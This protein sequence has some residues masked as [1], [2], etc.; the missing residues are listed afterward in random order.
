MLLEAFSGDIAKICIYT[1]PKLYE[2]DDID[3][4]IFLVKISI[5]LKLNLF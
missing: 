3:K 1:F 2:F 5:S 4:L